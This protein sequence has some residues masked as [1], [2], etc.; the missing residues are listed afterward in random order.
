MNIKNTR[1]KPNTKIKNGQLQPQNQYLWGHCERNCGYFSRFYPIFQG[2][3]EET[4]AV[5]II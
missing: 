3:G 4:A 5:T 2:W 1:S